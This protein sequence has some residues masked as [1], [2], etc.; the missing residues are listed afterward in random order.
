MAEIVNLRTA[1]KRRERAE[2]ERRAD[3]NRSL[4]GRSKT[5]KTAL[6]TRRER[7]RA[8]HDGHRRVSTP[9]PAAAPGDGETTP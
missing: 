8:A 6:A 9:T 2:K 7:E 4:H 1:R 3:E 5:E